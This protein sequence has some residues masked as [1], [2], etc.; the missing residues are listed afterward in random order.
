MS[1]V[2]R[3]VTRLAGERRSPPSH[4]VAARVS[5]GIAKSTFAL[6]VC[7]TVWGGL[8]QQA[9]AGRYDLDL[10]RLGRLGPGGN[11]VQRFDGLFRAL[12]SELGT[13]MAPRPTDPADSLGLAGFAISAGI[14]TSTIS[15]QEQFWT[16]VTKAP[17]LGAVG[18]LQLMVRKGLWPGLELG[19][20]GTKLFGSRMWSVHGYLKAA[21]HEGFHHLP[22]PSIALKVSAGQVLGARALGLTTISGDITV[23]HSFGIAKTMHLTPYIGYQSLTILAKTNTLQTSPGQDPYPDAMVDP[24]A[25]GGPGR[26]CPGSEFAFS[27]QV[28]VRHRP[29]L[30]V[31]MNFGVFR[32]AIE[33]MLATPGKSQERVS[34]I[35]TRDTAGLQQQ[36][37]LSMG[38]DF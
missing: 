13:V 28:I 8:P 30:G 15:H 26:P 36:Y 1:V 21:L 38:L 23:S 10:S 24:E 31:R 25:C 16:R 5:R 6:A 19:A 12:S 22:I 20:G 32:V 35:P 11:T 34:G 33:A 18:S 7:I 14:G 37:A 4:S 9:Q 3:L 17:P 2:S 29:F 27:R